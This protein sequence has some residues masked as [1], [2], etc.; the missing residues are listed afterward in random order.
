MNCSL[1]ERPYFACKIVVLVIWIVSI[2]ACVNLRTMKQSDV[3]DT[4]AS[5]TANATASQTIPVAEQTTL[6]K[7]QVAVKLDPDILVAKSLYAKPNLYQQH[8]QQNNP[9]QRKFLLQALAAYSNENW[10]TGLAHI[11]QASALGKLNSAAYVLKSDLALALNNA[12]LAII[13]LQSALEV[14]KYDAKALNRLASLMREQGDFSRAL[15]LLNRAI[16]ATP[17]DAASYRNRGVLYDLYLN[18][19]PQARVDYQHYLA[20]LKLDNSRSDASVDK[21]KTD[22]V[23]KNIKLVSRW[24]VDLSRQIKTSERAQQ[25]QIGSE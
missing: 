2:S 6:D 1:K 7:E 16:A 10:Q 21:V 23:E 17:S 20:L 15:S 19:K 12:E 9:A 8:Y 11:E 4:R 14:N 25:S 24:L 5:E 18:Q 22:Q 3:E 13:A